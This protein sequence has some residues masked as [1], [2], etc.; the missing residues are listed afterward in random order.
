MKEIMDQ[1]SRHI[2]DEDVER[3]L[4]AYASARLSPDHWASNRMRAA[5]IEHARTAQSAP[6]RRLDVLGR[7]GLGL[8]RLSFVALVAALAIMVGTSAGVAAAPGGPL[9]GV[10]VQIETALLPA[11]GVARTD[12]QVGLLDERTDEI[13]NAIDAGDVN[14]ADAAANAYGNQVDQAIS[15]TDQGSTVTAQRIADLQQLRTAL[16]RQLA[17][18]QSIGRPNDKSEANLQRLIART[19]AAIVAI[20]AQLAALGG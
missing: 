18:F 1:G 14:A 4:G 13:T 17:H 7:L 2:G 15:S 16:A 10:R 6:A 8:R 5:V 11:T 19:Q 20:D 9:Y 12:G 3:T